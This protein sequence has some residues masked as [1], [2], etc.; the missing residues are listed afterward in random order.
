M[1]GC[2]VIHIRGPTQGSYQQGLLFWSASNTLLDNSDIGKAFIGD[3]NRR[4][5]SIM[6]T[7]NEF[8]L[9]KWKYPGFPVGKNVLGIS[10]PYTPREWKSYKVVIYTLRWASEAGHGVALCPASEFLLTSVENNWMNYAS[11]MFCLDQ[12]FPINGMFMVPRIG[13][14]GLHF[15]LQ[16]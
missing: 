4:L 8:S 5:V 9:E 13:G 12:T 7:R 14:L 2:S 11:G 10:F 3:S 1:C 16:K 6:M 15:S